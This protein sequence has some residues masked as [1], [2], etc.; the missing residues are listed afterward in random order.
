MLRLLLT[1]GATPSPRL[2]ELLLPV[3]SLRPPPPPPPATLRDY[4][5]R[6][7]LV[8]A[9]FSTPL[10]R[11]GL[12]VSLASGSRFFWF[13]ASG[14]SPCP[15]PPL[16]PLTGFVCRSPRYF[17]NAFRPQARFTRFRLRVQVCVAVQLAASLRPPPPPLLL[18][19]RRGMIRRPS[20][21]VI[22][23]RFRSLPTIFFRTIPRMNVMQISQRYLRALGYSAS[24]GVLL[25]R[26]GSWIFPTVVSFSVRHFRAFGFFGRV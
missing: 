11:P 23:R 26:L 20:R 7:P 15:P 4:G 18:R 17:L 21:M 14:F 8:S 3:R 19:F 10:A 12:G 13:S 25:F 6:A 22:L 5:F 16:P 24:R 9:P 2:L 1:L